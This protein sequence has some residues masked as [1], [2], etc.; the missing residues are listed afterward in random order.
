M[1][2]DAGVQFGNPGAMRRPRN[3]WGEERALGCAT[4]G[5]LSHFLQD[6]LDLCIELAC[7]VVVAHAVVEKALHARELL[8][9]LLSKLA[10][11]PNH[12]L[13]AR[14]KVRHALLEQDGDLAHELVVEQ[15][16]DFLGLVELLL[17][18]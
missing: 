2:C 15:V 8:V 11:H 17:C 6:A 4:N 9:T 3:K 7:G 1:G 16:E 14:I 5:Q 10:L 18:L 13:E 12:R